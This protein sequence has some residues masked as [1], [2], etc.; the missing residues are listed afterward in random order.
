MLSIYK[1]EDY[2]NHLQNKVNV[3]FDHF[4]YIKLFKSLLHY[5]SEYDLNAESKSKNDLKMIDVRISELC[6]ALLETIN[7]LTIRE[8]SID[9]MIRAEH[10]EKSD[11]EVLKAIYNKLERIRKK[12]YE[13]YD[14]INENR[15]EFYKQLKKKT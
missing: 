3:L 4:T 15:I 2:I 10:L 9:S 14:S 13:F 7:Q 11:K 12:Y 1:H 8:L 5:T 6:I